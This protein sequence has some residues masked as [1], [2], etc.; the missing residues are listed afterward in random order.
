M[1]SYGAA[2]RQPGRGVGL[3]VREVRDAL[4]HL[5]DLPYLQTHPLA[6]RAGGGKGLRQ[7]LEDSVASLG[8]SGRL[9]V[10][11]RLRYVDGLEPADV[12]T[13]LAISKSEYYHAHRRA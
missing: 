11:L 4:G 1:R 5:Y 12:W 13:R 8:G 3:P 10:L 9:A 2:E 6:A 7:L